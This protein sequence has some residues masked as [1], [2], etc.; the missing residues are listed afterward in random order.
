VEKLYKCLFILLVLIYKGAIAQT[1]NPQIH[2]LENNS[3]ITKYLNNRLYLYLA[4]EYS[5]FKTKLLSFNPENLQQYGSIKLEPQRCTTD[6]NNWSAPTKIKPSLNSNSN[7]LIIPNWAYSNFSVVQCPE[8]ER[9]FR[10]GWNWVSFPKL[11]RE[12]DDPVDLAPLLNTMDPMPN[13]MLVQHR[14]NTPDNP[15]T[16]A[17]YVYPNTWTF[18]NL[19]DLQSSKG[20]KIEITD[21]NDEF[22]LSTPGTRLNVD[23]SLMLVGNMVENWIG[24]FEN[25]TSDP[26]DALEYCIDNLRWI[27]GQYWSA[28]YEVI[29]VDKGS[30]VYGW[31]MSRPQP[32]KYGDMLVVQGIN[33]CELIWN[34]EAEPGG[35]EKAETSYFEYEEQADYTSIFIELDDTT[36]VI[37]I[38]AFVDETCVGATV[39][40]EGDSLVEIQTYLQ[41]AEG[42]ELYFQTYSPNKSAPTNNRDYYVKDFNTLQYVNRK[43]RP[44][45]QKPFHLVSFKNEAVEIQ[46]NIIV[47]HYPTPALEEV[48]IHFN[49]PEDGQISLELM[50]LNGKLI[51]KVDLGYYPLGTNE[52]IYKIPQALSKGVYLYKFITENTTVVN[53]LVVQ[54]CLE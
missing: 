25:R 19:E 41:G 5:D 11:E 50:D 47:Y 14:L 42:D 43:I 39:V 18:T 52:Y 6:L 9:T 49:L 16:W 13:Q 29:D 32:L 17:V 27:K 31:I 28:H 40:E 26:F 53:H 10:N 24:Y 15:M 23:Y 54:K 45:D 2:Y 34:Q 33:D 36:D 21:G 37:E 20:Y 8:E 1:S 35:K 7:Q 51:E 46:D 12:N 38:G 3:P 48:T 44:Y 4:F 30:P 22:Q